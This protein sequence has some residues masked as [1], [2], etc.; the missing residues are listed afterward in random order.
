MNSGGIPPP[1][2]K[3]FLLCGDAGLD[4]QRRFVLIDPLVSFRV[5]AF[6]M[7]LKLTVYMR[8][9]AVRSDFQLVLEITN[10]D[11]TR[12]KPVPLPSQTGHRDPFASPGYCWQ[13]QPFHFPH[14]GRY[15]IAV[16]IDGQ[17]VY[18]DSILVSLAG[19]AEEPGEQGGG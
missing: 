9:T 13:G 14:A 11:G 12:G 1:I 15:E 2:V 18:T 10:P 5:R 3:A 17:E 6:P 4:A 8:L 7:D 16:M 19:S